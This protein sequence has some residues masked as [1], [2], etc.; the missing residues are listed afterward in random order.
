MRNGE[1]LDVE[2]SHG[3]WRPGD[4]RVYISDI[5]RAEADLGWAPR[6]SF[7]EGT[8]RLRSW[9]ETTLVV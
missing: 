5:R 2:V 4:Q 6:T 7:A 9:L 3:E 8:G 1:G